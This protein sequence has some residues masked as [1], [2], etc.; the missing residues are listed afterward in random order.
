MTNLDTRFK[1]AAME[2][3]FDAGLVVA[4]AHRTVVRRR[5]RRTAGVAV[6]AIAVVLGATAVWSVAGSEDRVADPAAP[7][8]P[9]GVPLTADSTTI[10]ATL[11]EAAH[12]VLGSLIQGMPVRFQLFDQDMAPLA[13]SASGDPSATRIEFGAEF[14]GHNWYIYAGRA[15]DPPTDPAASCDGARATGLSCTA[16]RAKDGSVVVSE[17]VVA[18][19]VPG[20]STPDGPAFSVVHPTEITKNQYPSVRFERSVTLIRPD[21]TKIAVIE[22]VYGPDAL[23]ASAFQSTLKQQKVLAGDPRLR[24]K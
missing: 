14:V 9:K 21:G 16:E 12:Q 2:T 19:R 24:W 23:D 17:E 6:S 15:V 8:P 13:A 18:L 4:N 3:E 5:R 20:L 7:P 11:E 10:R 1:A 22:T